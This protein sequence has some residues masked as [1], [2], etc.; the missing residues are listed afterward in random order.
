MESGPA[1]RSLARNLYLNGWKSFIR[2]VLVIRDAEILVR[3]L[4]IC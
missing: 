4:E 1:K 2:A 3:I